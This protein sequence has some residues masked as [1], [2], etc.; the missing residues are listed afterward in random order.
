MPTYDEIVQQQADK[1]KSENDAAAAKELEAAEKEKQQQGGGEG[2]RLTQEQI[3]AQAIADKK[4]EDEKK[5]A[6]A[7]KGKANTDSPPDSPP[8]ALAELL[9]ELKLENK[10]QLLERLR[11]KDKKELSPEEKKRQEDVYKAN[12]LNYAVENS[13]LSTEDYHKF[14]TIKGKA[15]QELV[16]E[17]YLQEWKEDNPD[18]K[19]DV[20]TKAKL[21]FDAEYKLNSENAKAKARGEAKIKSEAELLRKPFESSFNDA[22]SRYDQEVEL[23]NAWPTYQQSVTKIVGESMP[24]KY[25]FFKGKD[26]DEDVQLG[27]DISEEDKKEIIESLTKKFTSPQT[28]ALHKAGKT[29]DLQA[30][31]KDEAERLLWKKYDQVSKEEIAKEFM[32]RGTKKGSTIGAK[33]PFNNKQEQENTSG[34]KSKAEAEQEVLKQFK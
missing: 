22:K 34:K 4:L 20:D 28:Y 31:I 24:S 32:T 2:E 9:K 1:I 30:M 10:D 27:K 33:A 5:L 17:K 15:D 18:E 16:F 23:R 11:E 7:D 3:D 6:E 14:E 12:L 8:D 26:G 21:D 13:I 25:E 19:D 29:E